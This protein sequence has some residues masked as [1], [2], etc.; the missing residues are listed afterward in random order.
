MKDPKYLD[1][2]IG[3]LGP[4]EVPACQDGVLGTIANSGLPWYEEYVEE[5]LSHVLNGMMYALVGLRD[6]AISARHQCAAELFRVG[7]NSLVRALPDFDS[8]FWSWYSISDDDKPLTASMGYHTLHV[9]LLR[10]IADATDMAVLGQWADRFEAYTLN[11]G[12]RF[13]AAS[14]IFRDKMRKKK[15]FVLGQHVHV[16]AK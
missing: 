7:V 13:R 16:V 15:R 3:L 2:A 11:P 5:P 9:C 1:F 6:M 10:A 12:S 14:H 8:G 4:F